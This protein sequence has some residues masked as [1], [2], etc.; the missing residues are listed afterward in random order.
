MNTISRA[1]LDGTEMNQ[2]RIRGAHDPVSIAVDGTSIYWDTLVRILGQLLST[3]AVLAISV[4]RA[5]RR[6]SP[7]PIATV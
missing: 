6:P 1:N 7:G 5:R 3:I 2:S 4:R